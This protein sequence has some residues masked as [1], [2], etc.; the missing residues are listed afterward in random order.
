MGAFWAWSFCPPKKLAPMPLPTELPRQLSW[1]GQI[2]HT[3]QGKAS[4]SDKHTCSIVS[5]TLAVHTCTCMGYACNACKVLV[6]EQ[7]RV[8]PA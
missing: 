5:F 2:T 6:H 8:S 3:N 7:D 1:L 4:Q